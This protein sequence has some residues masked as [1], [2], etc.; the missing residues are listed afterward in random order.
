[1]EYSLLLCITYCVAWRTHTGRVPP[2]GATMPATT[3]RKM[4]QMVTKNS[5]IDTK[6]SQKISNLKLIYTFRNKKDK[7]CWKINPKNNVET[8]LPEIPEIL[9]CVCSKNGT[10]KLIKSGFVGC[11]TRLQ[12]VG[13]W[14]LA[15][16]PIN[17]SISAHAPVCAPLRGRVLGAKCADNFR[18]I[19][20]SK[21]CEINIRWRNG[22]SIL[23][24]FDSEILFV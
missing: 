13:E 1:M 21:T 3:I 9:R 11:M 16:R 7:F 4:I 12:I 8:N 5:D 19:D 24:V 18:P 6:S 22:Y 15:A 23:F 17:R 14:W 10:R 20:W 2:Q